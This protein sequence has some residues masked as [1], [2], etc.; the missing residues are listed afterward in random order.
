MNKK[1]LITATAAML[2]FVACS[3]DKTAGAA[4][5]GN[6]AAD[7]TG[8]EKAYMDSLLNSFGSV[9]SVSDGTG[10][11]TTPSTSIEVSPVL[12]YFKSESDRIYKDQIVSKGICYV[13]LNAEEQGAT[14]AKSRGSYEDHITTVLLREHEGAFY[15]QDLYYSLNTKPEDC[16]T[17]GA[18][19]VSACEENGGLSKIYGNCAEGT[20][21]ESSCVVKITDETSLNSIAGELVKECKSHME[22]VSLMDD[23]EKINGEYCQGDTENGMTCESAK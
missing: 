1:I 5:E 20:L 11:V 12:Y 4:V 7:L 9:G 21:F 6:A 2:A 16:K 14:I 23:P 13:D 17:D 10:D 22:E 18:A 3:D 19:F 15:K 8:S